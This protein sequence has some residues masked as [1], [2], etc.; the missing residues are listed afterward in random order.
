MCLLWWLNDLV[1]VCVCV[2]ACVGVDVCT[3]VCLLYLLVFLLM[4][5]REYRWVWWVFVDVMGVCLF[6]LSLCE[7][8]RECMSG[9][10]ACLRVCVCMCVSVCLCVDGLDMSV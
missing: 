10:W 9:G 6:C 5:V 1:G 2:C 3:L 4:S 7:L 8:G